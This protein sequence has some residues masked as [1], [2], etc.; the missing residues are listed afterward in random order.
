MLLCN[1][2]RV[3]IIV[4]VFIVLLPI[5]LVFPLSGEGY[6]A[7]FGTIIVIRFQLNEYPFLLHRIEIPQSYSFMCL[8]FRMRKIVLKIFHDVLIVACFPV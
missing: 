2:D 5:G 8:S 6:M 1:V 4:G 7:F 3:W